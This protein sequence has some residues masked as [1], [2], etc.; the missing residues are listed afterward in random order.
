MGPVLIAGGGI[1]G[2]AAALALHRR[3]VG[4][5]VYE[6]APELKE[7]GAGLS[8]W[9]NATHVLADLGVLDRVEA[10]GWPIG[11]VAVRT[12]RGA[13]LV[14]I[15]PWMG[16][17]PSLVLHRADLLDALADALPPG[18]VHLGR[19]VTGFAQE[20]GGATLRFTDGGEARGSAV[21][22]ADGLHSRV[23]VGLHGDAPP[24]YRGY[25]IRRGILDGTYPGHERG[26]GTETLGRGL[27]FGLFGVGGGRAYWYT[28][29]RAPEGAPGD[30]RGEAAHLAARFGDWP[31]PIP[32]V[33]AAVDPAAVLR[34]DAYDRPPLRGW[35]RGRVTLLGDAA[36]PTTPNLGQGACMALE[37]ALVLARCLAA[38]PDVPAALARY[39][40]RRRRRTARI[41]RESRWFGAVGQWAHPAAVAVRN[42]LGRAMPDALTAGSIRSTHGYRA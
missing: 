38:E 12:D 35:G 18:V 21:V 24:V 33:L 13:A 34:N 22:G 3:G 25:T 41:V 7:V 14:T 15:R 19:T 1:G 39:E 37:D 32:A 36:H 6:R 29:E 23:R 30:P 5:A 4:V 40:A 28:G 26:W 16:G 20:A 31:D 2:L 27:R 9:P 8:L 11:E 42:A 10:H 17:T